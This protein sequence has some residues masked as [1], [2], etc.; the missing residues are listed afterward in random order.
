MAM[1]KGFCIRCHTTDPR[2]RI[3]LVNSES[4]KCFCPRCMAEYRPKD[5]I[6]YYNH[7]IKV[8]CKRANTFLYTAKRPDLSYDKFGR[9]LEFEPEFPTA[10]LG[11]LAS[12]FYLST[13]R[14]SRFDDVVTLISLDNDRY[15][16]VGCREDYYNFLK[17]ADADAE[18]YRLRIFRLL[19]LKNYFYDMECLKLYVSRLNEIISFKKFI[20][21]EL[22]IIGFEKDA[23]EI[24][25][26]LKDL[27]E[28]LNDVSYY[29]I[30]GFVHRFKGFEKNGAIL[31]LDSQESI[32]TSLTKY[33]PSALYPKDKSAIYI[34]DQIFRSNKTS[35]TIAMVELVL[36]IISSSLG[37]TFLFTSLLVSHPLSIAFLLIGLTLFVVGG[38][39]ILWHFIYKKIMGKRNF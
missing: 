13:L 23:K 26:E 39:L 38:F 8:A 9:V 27:N 12:L 7:F 17:T 10:L 33:R 16:L 35:Y 3:F 20:Q 25:N 14:R 22:S 34:K 31:F 37:F 19:T 21:K 32:D 36:G 1:K 15:H 5:A 28:R 6:N 4:T 29:T 30:D 11:R 24:D 2:R 18:T